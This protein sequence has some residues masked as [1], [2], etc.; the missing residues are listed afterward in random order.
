[1]ASRALQHVRTSWVSA[2]IAQD[3]M[4]FHHDT[5]WKIR[6]HP[7]DVLGAMEVLL[8]GTWSQMS[9]DCKLQDRYRDSMERSWDKKEMRERLRSAVRRKLLLGELGRPRP[10]P[11]KN[12]TTSSNYDDDD[13]DF[14]WNVVLE[15][16]GTSIRVHH[17]KPRKEG[18]DVVYPMEARL[19]VL[20]ESDTIPLEE[21]GEQ[22]TSI[23]SGNGT[24]A[25]SKYPYPAQWTLLSIQIKT[26]VKTGESNYQLE[27]SK[28]Q[29]FGFH[30]ICERAMMQEEL[31]AKKARDALAMTKP[32]GNE[33]EHENENGTH[34]NENNSN[35]KEDEDLMVARPL[36]KLLHISHEFSI[37]WQMEILSSQA[38]ALRK[39]SWAPRHQNSGNSTITAASVGRG[40]GSASDG[41]GITVAPVRFL[42]EEEQWEWQGGGTGINSNG[43]SG[44]DAG[45]GSGSGSGTALNST[46][47]SN[48]KGEKV[49]VKPLAYL[50]IHFWEIDDRNGKPQIGPLHDPNKVMSAR[51]S[52]N[53]NAKT[54][55]SFPVM[56]LS[57]ASSAKRLTLEIRAVPGK[58]LE[59]SLSGGG[60]VM[61]LIENANT[62]DSNDNGAPAQNSHRN[63]SYLKRNVGMLLS[64][65]QDPF[66]LSVG[67]ALLAAVVICA[68]RRCH[69]IVRALSKT[70]QGQG[71]T[72]I[73]NGNNDGEK[74]LPPWMHLSVEC[75]SIAVSV[76]ISY[77][78]KDPVQ[79]QNENQN[80]PSVLIFRLAC[81]SRTGRFVPT[82]P[83]ATSLLRRLVCNDPSASEI[84]QLRQ[85]KAA[86]ESSNQ[87]STSLSSSSDKRRAA[88]RAKELT[89]R[90]LRD[91]FTSLTRSI[92][93]LGRRVGVGEWDD[94]DSTSL[95][96]REK[97]IAQACGDVCVSLMSCAGMSAVY[98]VGALAIGVAGGTNALPDM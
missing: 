75:G 35:G 89:G 30:Q 48:L 26:S 42:T 50:A 97:S 21:T 3:A 24:N 92:D 13:D 18:K 91:A 81:D 16:D 68:D 85:I 9:Q 69:A 63:S 76:K 28:E 44:N 39:G 47:N 49:R 12:H 57:D 62:N 7:H 79:E 61:S 51:G 29:M 31:R 17:G 5:L 23:T 65:L 53:A 38:E 82:F 46:A 88:A 37:S 66:E 54:V 36:E 77:H 4:Y 1:M 59:V 10:R 34:D 96:L 70:R 20:S 58:G 56:S 40:E 6:S 90:S 71:N 55:T 32:G 60:A 15:K 33:N 80:R 2:D 11:T 84:Q 27:L 87:S 64:S 93:V 52:D 74:S 83:S 25:I 45:S 95:A 19:A 94:I 8:N 41:A 72:N 14:K 43:G 86:S 98:G 73:T 67:N 78:G 22:K